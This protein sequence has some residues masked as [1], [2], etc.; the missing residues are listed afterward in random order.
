MLHTG[1]YWPV[2]YYTDLGGV[3]TYLAAVNDVSQVVNFSY[4]EFTLTQ[5]C[6]QY[7]LMEVVKDTSEMTLMFVIASN[8]Y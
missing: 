3:A 6:I 8:I 4:T 7:V 5:F 2:L 1:W